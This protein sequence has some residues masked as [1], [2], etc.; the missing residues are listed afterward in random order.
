ME[1]ASRVVMVTGGTGVIGGAIARRLAA[2]R[3]AVAAL[4]D[5]CRR[6]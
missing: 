1:T 6:Y 5:A 3:A 4:H 2:D